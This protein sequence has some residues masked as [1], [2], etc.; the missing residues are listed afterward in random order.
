LSVILKA[1]QLKDGDKL[2]PKNL[3]GEW[4]FTSFENFAANSTE[5]EGVSIQIKSAYFKYYS[6]LALHN[7][8][9][10]YKA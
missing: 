8:T 2:Y 6:A 9:H 1:D 7:S 5:G 3:V 4:A 10:P